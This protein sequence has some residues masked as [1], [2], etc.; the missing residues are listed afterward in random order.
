MTPGSLVPPIAGHELFVYLLQAAT[1]LLLALGL[2]RLAT[3][4]G[5]PAIVGELLAGVLIGPSLLGHFAP[6]ASGWLFPHR[7]DQFHLLDGLGQIAVVLLVGVTG[8][9]IDAG[10]VWR[11]RATAARVS[12]PGLLIPLGLGTAAGYLLPASLVP[13]AISR[14]IFAFFIG[15]AMCVSA[16]PVIAK[17]LIDMK[18]LHRNIGQLTLA[19]ATVDD[20][21]GWLML[22][23]VSAMAVSGIRA[24]G[25][26]LSIGCL[27]AFIAIA[28]IVRPLVRAFMRLATKSADDG[29]ITAVIVAIVILGAAVSQA[30]RLEA[31][32][33]AFVAGIFVGTC[34]H[35]KPAQLRPLRILVLS[36]LAP[37]FFASAGLQINLTTLVHPAVIAAAA[38]ILLIAIAGKF[39]GAYVGAVASHLNKWEALA[40]GAGMNSRGVVQLVVATVGLRL[41][42]LNIQSY[43]IIVL[44]AIATSLLAPPILRTAV[45]RIERTAEERL[46]EEERAVTPSA[47]DGRRLSG[48]RQPEVI[49]E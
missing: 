19:A 18:L 25:I 42:V 32:F 13:G 6:A 33:G 48:T 5:M 43:T 24:S 10:L 11:R 34:G 21:L 2:G 45:A 46:R 15:V 16:I 1:L 23:I 9:Q 39:I 40:L 47:G 17:T 38:A 35:L 44:T 29:V 41:G 36:V 12:I 37:I 14:G 30:L 20:A 49:G 3:R 7:P 26:A 27:A 28:F 4:L 8:A 31:V 22:S